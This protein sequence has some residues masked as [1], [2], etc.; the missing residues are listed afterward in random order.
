[1]SEQLIGRF[2]ILKEL[3]KGGQ[4]V[5]YLA[6]DPQLD[7]Q[8]I[9]NT[10]RNFSSKHEQLM[11]E[12]RIISKL[13]HPNIVPLFDTGVHQGVPFLVYAYIEGKTLEQLLKQ[14]NTLPFVQAAEIICGVLEGL[15]HA[16]AQGVIHLDVK[17]ANVM[18]DNNGLPMLMNF[19][20]ATDSG[21]LGQNNSVIISGTP[22]Y[23]APER[24]SGGEIDALADI[25]AVGVMLYE[26]VTG[27]SAVSGDNVYTVLNRAEHQGIAAPSTHNERVDEKLENIILKAVAKTAEER[28]PTAVMMKQALQDY[29]GDTHHEAS[30]M[31]GTHGTLEF[32]LRRMRSKSDFPALS[33]I[34]SEINKIVSSESE[35]SSKLARTILGDFALTNKL[36]KLV[37]TASYGQFG[38]TINTISKAV[39]ILGFE[40]VSNIAMT[41]ILMEFMQ[42]K[43]QAVQLKDEVVK[44]IFSSIVAAQLS[45]GHNIRDA[46]EIMV[47]AMFHNLGRILATFY[48]FDESQDISRLVEQGESEDKAAI[49]VLG[50][51]YPELGLG[52][53][54]SWNFPPRLMAG[55]RKL[56]GGKVNATNSDLEYIT[57]TVN[58]AHELS[59]IAAAPDPENKHQSLVK[60]IKRYE[61]ATKVSERELS[62]AIEG[63]LKELAIRSGILGI[64][65]HKSPLLQR[66]KEWSGHAATPVQANEQNELTGITDLSQPVTLKDDQVDATPPNLEAILGAGIQDVT[67]SLVTDFNLNDVLQMV[68]E[69]I[70]RGVGF[71]RALVLIR[72]NKLNIMVA[73]FGFGAGI[74]AVIPLCRFPL[75][76]AADVFHLSIEKGLDIAIEDI[77]A[78]NIAD[79]IPAWYRSAINA[80]CFMLLPIML[81]GKAIGLFYADM[82]QPNSLNL[83]QQQLSLLRTLRN[84]AVLA[85]KQKS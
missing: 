6:R 15:A 38:G 9:I 20:L 10:L 3:G 33:H 14:Q 69:T 64:N 42:N 83:T 66:V 60:L 82:L 77:N 48:F 37:N 74:D 78:P 28:Y 22:Q 25:Y 40:T 84:Q 2:E 49:K 73:R 58:L 18:I 79:K 53:A 63:G 47:C 35:S 7:R 34:I 43:A 29:L 23:M 13:Q 26:M 70:Y 45:V 51:S 50:I 54:R 85:I 44:S 68:L 71:N 11:H 52:V 65:T 17:P 75:P 57:V 27:E 39:V 72:D 12:A 8:V 31:N 24:I 46:E 56:S 32:L 36:L 16:H 21:G 67:A 59:H 4:G 55:M 61:R 81:K 30:I 1:M 76:F 62:D 41:L 5:V 19:S 80:P